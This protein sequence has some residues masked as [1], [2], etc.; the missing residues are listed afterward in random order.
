MLW[1]CSQL[2]ENQVAKQMWAVGGLRAM[3]EKCMR[4]SRAQ[5]R[6]ACSPAGLKEGFHYQ[7]GDI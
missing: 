1:M 2:V 5:Q 3:R 7:E 4:Y 6:E